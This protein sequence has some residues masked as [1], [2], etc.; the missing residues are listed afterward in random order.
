MHADSRDFVVRWKEN[1]T[2]EKLR[3]R[4]I[5]LHF[6]LENTR[7]YSYRLAA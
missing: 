2:L 6:Y 4:P 7:L 3:G 1:A 5:R